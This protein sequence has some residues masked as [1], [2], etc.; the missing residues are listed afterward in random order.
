MYNVKF[1]VSDN[2]FTTGHYIWGRKTHDFEMILNLSTM[3]FSRVSKNDLVVIG[4][5][6][7]HKSISVWSRP[8]LS[9][10]FAPNSTIPINDTVLDATINFDGSLLAVATITRLYFYKCTQGIYKIYDMFMH[11]LSYSFLYPQVLTFDNFNIV[12]ARDNNQIKCFKLVDSAY[13]LYK[14]ISYPNMQ[15]WSIDTDHLIVKQDENV[16]VLKR[17]GIDFVE[18]QNLATTATAVGAKNGTLITANGTI[19]MVWKS[20]KS[21]LN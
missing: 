11:S 1:E 16:W 7:I 10:S 9:D 6:L 4:F 18:V 14:N 17:N 15:D 21:G 2:I 12:L 20:I 5:S 13:Q 8:S 3:I 19:I